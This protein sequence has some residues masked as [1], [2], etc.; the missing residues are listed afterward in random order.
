MPSGV[1]PRTEYHREI[2]RR[3]YNPTRFKK[4][5]IGLY[6]GKYGQA[7]THKQLQDAYFV[8]NPWCKTF[9]RIVTRCSIDKKSSYFGRVKNFLTR[10]D[11]KKLWFRDK[12]WLLLRPSID[13]INTT[14]NYELSNCRY[15]ELDKN[16]RR[17]RR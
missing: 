2:L 3:A 13:R 14:G 7:Q 10:E 12:A 4:G 11:L 5:H 17:E 1:Y 8:R 16:R 9:I 15:I 6:K